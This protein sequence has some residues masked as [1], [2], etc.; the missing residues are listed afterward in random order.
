MITYAQLR[1]IMPHAPAG[2]QRF[3]QPLNDAMEEF[4]INTPARQAAFLAQ[5]AHESGSFR[6]ME[7]IASGAAYEGRRDLGNHEQEA[8]DAAAAHGT[9]PGKFYKGHGPIQVTGYYNHRDCGMALDLDLINEPTLL[10]DPVH[11][12]R[13]AAWFWRSRGLNEMADLG[14]QETIT[15]RINGGLNGYSERMA[16]LDRATEILSEGVA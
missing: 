7:E 4:E 16:Y 3:V 14:R 11:G 10:T 9:T 12:C 8:I 15:R 1:A 13:A 5:L 2:L 6:Y